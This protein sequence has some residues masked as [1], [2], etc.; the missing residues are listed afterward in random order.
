M[1]EGFAL[2]HGKRDF[3]Y[4]HKQEAEHFVA[5]F[6]M[7]FFSFMQSLKEPPQ[8]V[9]LLDHPFMDVE[10]DMHTQ[11]NY[12]SFPFYKKYYKENG[13]EYGHI[14]WIDFDD[15]EGLEELAPWEIA[16]ILYIRHTFN[17]LRS[18]FYQKLNNRFVYLTLEDGFYNK[19]YYRYWNDFY[20]LI[21]KLIPE[22]VEMNRPER[23]WLGGK[24]RPENP[25]I[26]V[27][28]LKQLSPLLNEGVLISFHKSVQTRQSI[29]IPIWAVGDYRHEDE[30]RDDLK[31]IYQKRQTVNLVYQKKSKE[32]VID[33]K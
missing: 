13:K 27:D 16:E 6:G 25:I 17:H 5:S 21:A 10:Y 26:P 30:L 3:I 28:I 15:I 1:P 33:E 32:W 24:K 2:K 19:I 31:V 23:L 12:V 29:E 8:N 18:P 7:D 4:L 11:F 20:H 9:L 14:S 22:H